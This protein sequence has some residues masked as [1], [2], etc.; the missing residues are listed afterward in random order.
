MGLKLYAHKRFR[1]AVISQLM[2][3]MHI[4]LF[5]QTLCFLCYVLLPYMQQQLHNNLASNRHV[6]HFDVQGSYLPML[7]LNKSLKLAQ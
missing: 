6:I 1:K 7:L 4:A 5:Q 2:Q 3:V